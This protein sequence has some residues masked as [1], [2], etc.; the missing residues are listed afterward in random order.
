[1]KKTALICIFS[2]LLPAIVGISYIN[3]VKA[4]GMPPSANTEIEIDTPKN[5]TY[6]NN[7]VILSFYVWE[8]WRWFN[9]CYSV[10]GQGMK[11]VE[12]L[13]MINE[14][15]L[16]AGIYPEVI[17]ANL[18]GSCVLSNLTDGRHN[19]TVYQMSDTSGEILGS[20]TTEFATA[21]EVSPPESRTI[22]VLATTVSVAVAGAA[23]LL[24]L[25]KRK[26]RRVS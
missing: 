9:F 17:V 6:T 1:M 22:L 16:N 11:P 10:D 15:N 25:K 21:K 7:T 23:F 8:A 2:L 24:Y 3:M 13:V 12:D 14:W 26:R 5:K 4:N 20:V 19:V 18:R